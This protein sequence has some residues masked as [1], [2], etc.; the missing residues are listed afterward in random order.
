MHNI[1]TLE[2]GIAD[3][4]TTLQLQNTF[5]QQLIHNKSKKLQTNNTL[6]LCQHHNV[7]TI[8]KNGN[9]KNLLV[10]PSTLL[11]RGF[12]L[13]HTN[14][15]G[16]ITLHNPGQLVAYT[17]FDL[18]TLHLGV[19]QFVHTLENIII[20]LLQK[21]Q[22]EAQTIPN[23]PG[24][25]IANK[26]Q[27]NKIAALGLKVSHNVTMHGVAINVN[28]DLKPFQLINPCGF[29][30]K[31]VTSIQNELQHNVDVYSAQQQLVVLFNTTFSRNNLVE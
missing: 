8:G 20:Q 21:Y 17:I 15:G 23:A 2:L 14:R 9:D 6:L 31:G 16:D 29:N 10:T 4:L 27:I 3:Y 30:D 22:I 28:N 18:D 1:N 12:Q 7:I 13:Q 24:V 11:E 25:W 19:K 5:F 26:Q